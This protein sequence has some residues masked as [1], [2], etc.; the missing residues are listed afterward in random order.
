MLT[1]LETEYGPV[2]NIVGGRILV[3]E[4]DRAMRKLIARAL[5]NDGHRV[6]E[7]ASGRDALLR[8]GNAIHEGG[9]RFYDLVISDLRMPG[10]SGLD[11][12]AGL[13]ASDWSVPVILITAFGDAETHR[14]ARRLGAVSVLDKPFN[15]EL[16]SWLVRR[17]LP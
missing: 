6:T 12:L 5:R 3:A 17:L 16:L 2:P 4:D 11:L 10:P 13:R 14:Q 9:V 1:Q 8:L 15:L 7:A